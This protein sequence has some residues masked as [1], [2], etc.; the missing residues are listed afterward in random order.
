MGR[1][2][3]KQFYN[4]G[5]NMKELFSFLD[6][7]SYIEKSRKLSGK[8]SRNLENVQIL[9]SYHL[10]KNIIRDNIFLKGI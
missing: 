4:F 1:K 7:H 5:R 10:N 6:R 8:S 2:T 9:F 3:G